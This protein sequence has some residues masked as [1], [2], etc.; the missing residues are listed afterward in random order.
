MDS[1]REPQPPDPDEIDLDA[2][3]EDF[4]DRSGPD[5]AREPAVEP[6]DEDEPAG[7]EPRGG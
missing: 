4:A 2:L 5:P 3:L 6:L 7:D 1:E